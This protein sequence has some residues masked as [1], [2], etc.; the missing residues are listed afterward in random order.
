MVG[1]GRLGCGSLCSGADVK[2]NPLITQIISLITAR[3]TAMGIPGTPVQQAFQPTQQGTNTAPTAFLYKLHDKRR[4]TPQRSDVFDN[5]NNR[6]V[7]TQNQLYDTVFQ[8]SA[9]SAQDPANATQ[10]TASDLLNL[11]AAILTDDVTVAA[12]QAQGLG[13]LSIED[14]TNG[15]FIDDSGRYEA[16]PTFDFTIS[17]TQSLVTYGPYIDHTEFNILR[18]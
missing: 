10:L 12:F 11:V 18:V 6:S 3:E 1:A 7:H 16:A 5:V 2:D 9:L 15:Y 4:G 17:H 13:I 14:V 8:A